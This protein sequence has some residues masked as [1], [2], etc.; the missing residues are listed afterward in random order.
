MCHAVLGRADSLALDIGFCALVLFRTLS[1]PCTTLDH[2][3]HLLNALCP[4]CRRIPIGHACMLLIKP[5]RVALPS[6]YQARRHVIMLSVCRRIGRS[7]PAFRCCELRWSWRGVHV[8]TTGGCLCRCAWPPPPPQQQPC[9]RHG[10]SSCAL[11]WHE[12]STLC[13]TCGCCMQ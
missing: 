2:I 11:V 1:K 9:M 7:T 6:Y 3:Q 12:C 4:A 8:G 13:M 10:Q 5:C